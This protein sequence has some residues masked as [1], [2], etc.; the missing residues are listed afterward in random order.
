M[1]V[2][3]GNQAILFWRYLKFG[4]VAC[5]IV[6]LTVLGYVWITPAPLRSQP[7]PTD[8]RKAGTG[9]QEGSGNSIE[10]RKNGGLVQSTVTSENQIQGILQHERERLNALDNASRFLITAAGIFAILL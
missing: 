5:G 3:T 10:E 7:S 1:T 8:S 2:K 6:A 4:F 9:Q